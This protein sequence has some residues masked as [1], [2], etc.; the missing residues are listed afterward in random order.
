MA[1]GGPEREVRSV[2]IGLKKAARL[3]N[4]E[5][6]LLE[7]PGVVAGWGTRVGPLLKGKASQAQA[8]I[9]VVEARGGQSDGPG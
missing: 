7:S 4:M 3:V 9:V 1:V 6:R 8:W 5:W 2:V